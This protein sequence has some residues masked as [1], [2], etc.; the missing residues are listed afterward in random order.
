MGVGFGGLAFHHQKITSGTFPFLPFV[1]KKAGPTSLCP[2]ERLK[3]RKSDNE[4]ISKSFAA[5]LKVDQGR[6]SMPSQLHRSPCLAPYIGSGGYSLQ[7]SGQEQARCLVGHR[8]PATWSGAPHEQG[9]TLSHP[10]L[11]PPNSSAVG[12]LFSN[13]MCWELV[14]KCY[15][16]RTR[17][18]KMLNVKVLRPTKHYSLGDNGPWMKV[19]SNTI[20]K[21]ISS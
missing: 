10:G 14:L 8:G 16:L 12:H 11:G 20:T 1:K 6:P 7:Q 21:V 2:C 13:A 9:G 18:H 4:T 3:A 19:D 17:Q 5:R 15:E